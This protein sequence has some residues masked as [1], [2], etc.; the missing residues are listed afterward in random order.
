MAL[1]N[2]TAPQTSDSCTLMG[3]F[4]WKEEYLTNAVYINLVI[5]ACI[6]GISFPITSILNGLLI[7]F[8]IRRPMLR[9][10]KSTVA[11][12]YQAATDL[13][14]GIIVQPT[15][16]AT[17]LCR[18]TGKCRICLLD[19]IFYYL[20][21]VTCASSINH[22]LLIAWERYIAIKYALRYRLIVT[23][24]RLLAGTI[25]A[26]LFEITLNGVFFFGRIS[27]FS[28]NDI[29]KLL[30]T[31]ICLA[32]T[33]YFYIA[34]YVESRRHRVLITTSTPQ[35]GT[36]HIREFKAA[37][38]MAL[39]LGC[40]LIC[41]A[42]TCV[43]FTVTSIYPINSSNGSVWECI[44]IWAVT[45][46]LLNSLINPLLYGWRVQEIREVVASTFKWNENSRRQD[47]QT[48]MIEMTEHNNRERVNLRPVSAIGEYYNGVFADDLRRPS[49]K[50]SDTELI[51]E[52]CIINLNT[53]HASKLQA[54][55]GVY[56]NPSLH[57]NILEDTNSE[58]EYEPNERS[59]KKKG[60]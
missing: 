30:T 49:I 13:A 59:S 45:F 18:I 39:V 34:I 24:K 47:P 54:Q 56:R 36:N 12:G 21:V 19:S 2:I 29:V 53:E 6:N 40:L 15:F 48:D 33:V 8:I 25:A 3:D 42:P 35:Q 60:E 44:F 51:T 17:Q 38:T 5:S 32:I 10:K 27:S 26:W 20:S 52:T 55:F 50:R 31:I 16:V 11:I 7:F 4:G 9:R 43:L 58:G 57:E 1:A 14:V 37:K 41:Y 46:A 23:A 28:I 22:L